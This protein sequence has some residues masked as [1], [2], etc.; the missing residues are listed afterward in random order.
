MSWWLGAFTHEDAGD[1]DVREG[2]LEW[3]T[4]DGADAALEVV[5]AI[6]QAL[7]ESGFAIARR[8]DGEPQ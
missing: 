8:V 4:E 2:L 3:W 7:E 1:A 5:H 6:L